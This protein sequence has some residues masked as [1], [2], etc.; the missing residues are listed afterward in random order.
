VKPSASHLTWAAVL[1]PVALFLLGV[2]LATGA[3]WALFAAG[4]ATL[5][6]ITEG[7][8]GVHALASNI[9]QHT[10]RKD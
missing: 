8:A 9:D 1:F 7:A 5:G 4:A 10:Q 3:T 2:A 6:G